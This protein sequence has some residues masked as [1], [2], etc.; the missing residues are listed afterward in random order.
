MEQNALTMP[1]AVLASKNQPY[2]GVS[3]LTCWEH[4][5]FFLK[6]YEEAILATL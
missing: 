3:Q 2:T 5:F 1:K 6:D 4:Y